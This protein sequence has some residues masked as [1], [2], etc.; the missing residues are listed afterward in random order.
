MAHMG[1]P[2]C[3]AGVGR[4]SNGCQGVLRLWLMEN[5]DIQNR[6]AAAGEGGDRGL[7]LLNSF[8]V[9]Q[10]RQT[11]VTGNPTMYSWPREKRRCNR[12]SCT[13]PSS[14]PHFVQRHSPSMMTSISWFRFMKGMMN[15]QS[16][17]GL[18]PVCIWSVSSLYGVCI[19]EIAQRYQSSG[20]NMKAKETS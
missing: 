11:L 4:L 13:T 9:R 15:Q 1:H 6:V 18:Y 16:V 7:A 2:P 14:L 8:R 17:W 19:R 5:V 3:Q 12:S 10:P 20:W